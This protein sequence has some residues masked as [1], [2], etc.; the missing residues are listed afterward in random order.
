VNIY[1]VNFV[2]A[3]TGAGSLVYPV[4][5]GFVAILRDLDVYNNSA[6]TAELFLE[7]T[8]SGVAIARFD[9]TG[10]SDSGSKTWRGRQVFEAG[11][12]FTLRASAGTWDC[13]ASGYLL[14]AP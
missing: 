13:R 10:P 9:V 4:P 2:S 11:G 5:T 3:N 8:V 14:I 1:S 7:D 6:I 12:G